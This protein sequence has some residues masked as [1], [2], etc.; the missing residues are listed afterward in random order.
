MPPTSSPRSSTSPVCSPARISDPQA[1]H[2]LA[3]RDRAPQRPR[4]AVEDGEDAVAGRFHQPSAMRLDPRA[5]GGVVLVQQRLP[6]FVPGRRGP[7]GRAH[8]VGEQDRREDPVLLRDRVRARQEPLGLGQDRLGALEEREVI[9]PGE[10]EEGGV[11]DPF[12]HV[13]AGFDVARAVPQRVHH[14][15]RAPDRPEDA[16]DV[17]LGQRPEEDDVLPRAAGGEV[18]ARPPPPRRL[19]GGEARRDLGEHTRGGVPRSVRS[20]PGS[21][22]RAPPAWRPT[23]SPARRASR[24]GGNRASRPRTFARDTWRRTSRRPGRPGGSR[25]RAADRPCRVEHRRHVV[26]TLLE[27]ALDVAPIGQTAP[28]RVE[29]DQP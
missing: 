14:E 25:R 21:R 15:H 18:V 17:D 29:H 2:V 9:A 6:S 8:D 7:L 11:R 12:G 3:Q 23:G 16:A 24:P 4:R 27:S 26:Q 22:A 20:V 5:S 1:G 28:A 13:S 10:F 19:V